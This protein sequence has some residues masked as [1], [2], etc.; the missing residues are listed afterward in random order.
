MHCALSSFIRTALVRQLMNAVELEE[1]LLSARICF[2]A[3]KE[4]PGESPV[5]APVTLKPTPFSAVAFWR[6][7]QLQPAFNLLVWRTVQNGR[8]LKKVCSKLAQ[9]DAFV[10]KLFEIYCKYP[11]T[12]KVK[13][14]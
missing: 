13:Y 14:L 5:H 2:K 8:L 6:A 4:A 3:P 11:E 9:S 12:P 7:V 10:A 1:A